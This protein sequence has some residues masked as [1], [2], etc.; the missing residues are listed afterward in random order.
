[1]SVIE[2]Y[3][4]FIFKPGPEPKHFPY[5]RRSLDP[6][7][8]CTLVLGDG[9]TQGFLHAFDI[10][11]QCPC[12]VPDLFEQAPKLPYVRVVGDQFNDTA[13]LGDKTKWPRIAAA[14]EELGGIDPMD[15]FSRLAAQRLN[16]DV[17]NGLWTVDF[18]SL[19]FELRCYLWHYFRSID[20]IM[21]KHYAKGLDWS[22]WPWFELLEF[23]LSR[24]RFSC[25][26]FNYDRLLEHTLGT[27]SRPW[28]GGGQPAHFVEHSD[29]ALQTMPAHITPIV[30]VHGSID[31]ATGKH[32]TY[33][34]GWT[35]NPWLTMSRSYGVEVSGLYTERYDMLRFP[36]IPDIV[37]P[38]H[39]GDHLCNPGSR[40]ALLAQALI[41][42]SDVILV[43]GLSGDGADEPE[44]TEMFG[45][46]GPAT[47]V[48]HIGLD[49]DRQTAVATCLRQKLTASRFS[50]VD[51][52]KEM[53]SVQVLLEDWFHGS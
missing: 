20:S 5:L 36:P 26:T 2:G 24:F 6:R 17:K 34:H 29:E 51:A 22:R 49:R 38:G 27:I 11:G 43:C 14:R 32:L 3:S 39:A 45:H 9:F 19:A 31:H 21:G 41:R 18:N 15:F 10:Q 35:P 33:V 1:M 52:H 46:I 40:V 47:R 13:P 25:I 12:R 50:F 42:D 23:L 44:V 8:R 16:P 7:P 28:G 53:Q 4:K 48:A 30:K 37:P